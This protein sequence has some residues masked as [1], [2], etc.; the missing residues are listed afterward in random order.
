MEY[1]HLS[2]WLSKK[3]NQLVTL[4]QVGQVICAAIVYHLIIPHRGTLGAY[5]IGWGCLIPVVLWLP[6]QMLEDWDIQNHILKM[7]VTP[8]PMI[9][10]F[11]TIEAM[12]DTSPPVVE[13]SWANYLI[14]YTTTIHFIWDP[15]TKTRVQVDPRT[16]WRNFLRVAYYF[17][18]LSLSLSILR[19]FDYTPFS[20]PVVLDDFHLNLDL[21]RPGHVANMYLL[22]GKFKKKKTFVV[23]EARLLCQCGANLRQRWNECSN[24]LLNI[25]FTYSPY[26]FPSLGWI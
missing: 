4:C 9:V 13:S 21:F 20:S 2:S 5:L 15:R 10:V 23:A 12:Y 26:V 25:T 14:Y 18:W 7:C 16:L 1:S 24:K 17:H 8:L 22:A 3:Q 6:F 19:H 11:R